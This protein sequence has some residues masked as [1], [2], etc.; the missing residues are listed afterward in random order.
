MPRYGVPYKGSKNAIAEWVVDILPPGER[1][2]DLFAGGCA[3][4]HAAMLSGKWDR[5]LANDIGDGPEFFQ[6][7]I[8]GGVPERDKMDQPGGVF[9]AEGQRPVCEILLVI[10][11]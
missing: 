10:R 1:L 8:M 5:F 4:T 2:V 6:K 11:K 7:A 9:P 3:I